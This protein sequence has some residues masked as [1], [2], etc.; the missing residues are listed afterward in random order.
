MENVRRILGLVGKGIRWTV[1]GGGAAIIVSVTTFTVIT[2]VKTSAQVTFSGPGQLSAEVGKGFKYSFCDPTPSSP[3]DLCGGSFKIKNPTGGKGPYHF[4]LQTAGG[5]PPFGISLNL[6]GLLSGKPTAVGRRNFTVC[7]VDIA[8]ANSCQS[9]KFSVVENAQNQP[10]PAEEQKSAEP[11]TGLT[12]ANPSTQDAGRTQT[13]PQTLDTATTDTSV[14]EDSPTAS[15][16]ELSPADQLAGNWS[17]TFTISFKGSQYCSTY[18]N[19]WSAK[20][21]KSTDTS[22]SGKIYDANRALIGSGDGTWDGTQWNFALQGGILTN[23]DIIIT[24]N[25]LDGSAR[26]SENWIPCPDY[27][28]YTAKFD[29]DK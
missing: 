14:Q 7:A 5:F 22:G 17:G 25:S 27:S 29:G 6:N 16:V 1:V 10:V 4:Q 23:L 19:K 26:F 11:N 20:F 2:W 28:S 12:T 15:P 13:N 24:G 18:T 21:T 3:T 9:I 8:G